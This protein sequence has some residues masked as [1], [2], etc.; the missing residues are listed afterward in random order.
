MT[1]FGA[2]NA[3]GIRA[4]CR[5]DADYPHWLARIHEPPSPLWVHGRLP[6][7]G[8]PRS[9]AIVG[10][11]A[12]TP[13]GLSFARTLAA[14]LAAA[15]L[16]IVSGLA[17]G[18]D[19]AAHQGALDANGRTV[20]VLGSALDCVYPPENRP[21][22]EAIARSGALVSEFPPGT[23]PW[24]ANFPRRNR[25]IAGLTRALV[26]VEAGRKSG[27]LLT[28]AAALAEGR[29]VMAVPGHPALPG[30]AGTNALLRDGAAL[31]R[32]AGD[33]LAELGLGAALPH[34]AEPRDDVLAALSRGVPVSLDQIA[35]R[36]S[37]PL[38]ALLARLSELELA[39][40]L[41]RLPG[42]LFVRS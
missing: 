2:L 13:L 19:T 32:D 35:A 3:P 38:P 4:L 33:V 7:D 14:D 28:A 31:V 16:T 42:A 25:T 40:R 39:G 36:G 6:A 11:R 37:W 41:R 24:K 17:R 9:V 12:A 30:A 10:A 21:L 34:Q 18:I 22:A 15:G 1:L 27:A 23:R 5:D 29:E 26:V 8:G 20:A